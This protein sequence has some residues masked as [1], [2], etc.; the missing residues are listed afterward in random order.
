M[1]RTVEYPY[2]FGQ[3]LKVLEDIEYERG[4]FNVPYTLLKGTHVQFDGMRGEY[5]AATTANLSNMFVFL[6]PP[7]MVEAWSVK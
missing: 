5:I 2:S 7:E 3:T 6:I 1:A 4:P